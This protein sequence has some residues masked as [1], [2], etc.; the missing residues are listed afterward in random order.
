M[1]R[2][3]SQAQRFPFSASAV[4]A[5]RRL[6]STSDPFST[7]LDNLNKDA[8]KKREF[9]QDRD[10]RSGGRMSYNNRD[11]RD[12]RD[13]GRR[14]RY[15]GG[16]RSDNRSNVSDM[17]EGD[18]G[19]SQSFSRGGGGGGN[20]RDNRDFVDKLSATKIDF[21]NE[22][23]VEIDKNFYKEHDN[24]AKMTPEEVSTWRG[25]HNITLKGDAPNPILSFDD[26]SF[27]SVLTRQL[28]T[29]FQAPTPI[30][31][32]GWPLALSGRDMVGSSQTGSGKTLGFMLPALV[33]IQAQMAKSP[34]KWTD[35]PI[36]LV[37][38]PTRELAMQIQQEARKYLY[39]S[40]I[41][42]TAIFGGADRY[43]QERELRQGV[44]LLIATP[45]RLIDFMADNVINL[46]RVSY[47]VLD[48]A[49]R[50]LD[51]GFEP[52]MRAILRNIRPDR[53][54]LM[55]SATW[56]QKVQSI[57]REFFPKPYRHPRRIDGT[58]REPERHSKCL[59]RRS[60][61]KSNQVINNFERHHEGRADKD[62]DFHSNEDRR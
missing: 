56:P 8:E 30:Q 19:S 23:L 3:F 9:N 32:Q 48:E 7:I 21:T 38:V 6:F 52:Q 44:Q 35:G 39:I 2:L 62:F 43:R 12:N 15:S 4:F 31:S 24:I 16:G 17:F 51:M 57:A 45:G 26:T 27:P 37:L 11:N 28:K 29:D 40:R 59:H 1:L 61:I 5:T 50:M 36:A 41:N 18:D 34:H 55:W 58:P 60:H 42:A 22:K 47:V 13:Y 33:H 49:D 25:E 54:T 10:F 53:Q 46:K 20:R 14:D